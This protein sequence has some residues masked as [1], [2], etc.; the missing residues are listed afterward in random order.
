VRRVVPWVCLLAGTAHA[1]P[2]IT[3]RDYA[4]DFYEGAALGGTRQVGMGG[5]GV[6]SAIG[7]SGTL[8]NASA[9]AIRHT[10]DTDGWSWDYH[11]DYLTGSYSSD[12]DNNGIVLDS[13]T[14][15]AQ[16]FTS[17]LSLRIGNWAGAV[18]S[19]VQSAP[20][21][22][23]PALDARA[24]RLKFA[25]A[26]YF[27][28]IDTSIGVGIQSVSFQLLANDA[29]PLFDISGTGLLAGATWTP[30][31]QDFRIGVALE[32]RIDGGEVTTESCDPENCMLDGGPGY[33]LPNRVESS[34]RLGIGGAYRWAPTRWNQLVESDF[35]DE[36]AV[37][38]AADVWVTD[39]TQNGYGIEKFGMQ[40]LQRSGRHVSVGARVGGE[41]EAI[42]GR[43][44]LRAGSYWEPERFDTVGGRLHATFGIEL[45]VLEFPFFGRRRGRIG[46]TTDIAS[47]FRNIALA[48]GFWD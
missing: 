13:D 45:R 7:S 42:P 8:L 20:L 29:E 31:L 3:S 38:V 15:G 35:R 16:L 40:E 2:P 5:T 39:R 33:I 9:P 10:T 27:P 41:V 36:Q 26:K 12:Y 22:G 43:L 14:S 34:P 19:T 48:I 25:L 23:S 28:A 18:T 4:I 6:A 24:V 1:E 17:G 30:S 21:D 46:L 37:T 11:F 32:G 44:R 47:R